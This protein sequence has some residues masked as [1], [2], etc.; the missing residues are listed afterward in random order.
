MVFGR[1]RGR[2]RLI[3]KQQA[4]REGKRFHAFY[5][6]AMDR[7]AGRRTTINPFPPGSQEAACWEAGRRYADDERNAT[8]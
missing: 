6:G 2:R 3:E 4:R 7:R 5:R 8:T 1:N